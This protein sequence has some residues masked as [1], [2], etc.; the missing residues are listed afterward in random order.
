MEFKV[1]KIARLVLLIALIRSVL[2]LVYPFR[3]TMYKITLQELRN[4]VGKP[5]YY[6][7][8]RLFEEYIKNLFNQ[9]SFKTK[10]WRQA[11]KIPNDTFILDISYPD[12][13]LIFI[14][15][16]HYPFAVECKWRSG[17]CNGKVRWARK[18]QILKYEEFERKRAMTVFIAIG[19][20]GTPSNPE[21]LFVTPLCNLKGDTMVSE[22]QLIKYKRKPNRRFFYNTVIAELG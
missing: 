6:E 12:L 13:E 18:D 20:G 21:M 15:K 22:K 3:T 1:F 4:N 14:R 9:D 7:Q 10:K 8:G 17:F 16:N 5:D 2:Y 19:I 11:S